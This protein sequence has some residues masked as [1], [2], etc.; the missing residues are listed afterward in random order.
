MGSY[1]EPPP[2]RTPAGGPAAP[3]TPRARL[4]GD[5]A[6]QTSFL[7]ATVLPDLPLGTISQ[8]PFLRV[9]LPPPSSPALGLRPPDLPRKV[10]VA[11]APSPRTF[12]SR[13]SATRFIHPMC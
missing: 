13:V 11:I 8:A 6:P 3:Q 5:I 10:L 1:K 7:G 4:W 9:Y 12:N 2:P